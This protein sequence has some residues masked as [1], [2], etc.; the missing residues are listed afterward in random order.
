MTEHRSCF[1]DH[2]AEEKAFA[3]LRG[4]VCEN[5]KSLKLHGDRVDVTTLNGERYYIELGTAKVYNESGKFVCV[6]VLAPDFPIIDQVIAKSLYLLSHRDPL[7]ALGHDLLFKLTFAGVEP[8]LEWPWLKSISYSTLG[9]K[10]SN[11]IGADFAVKEISFREISVKLQMWYVNYDN[12]F[13]LI[14]LKHI[15]GSMGAIILCSSESDAQKII[16]VE[17]SIDELR[18]S[19]GGKLPIAFIGLY[20]GAEEEFEGEQTLKLGEEIAKR[21]N[22]PFFACSLDHPSMTKKPLAYVVEAILSRRFASKQGS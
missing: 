12:K 5:S 2:I 18:S 17:E 16:G 20:R 3:L 7:L 1:R 4:I 21:N 11:L 19:N 8:R 14:R 22:I 10:F 13:R 15:K 9:D 6:R